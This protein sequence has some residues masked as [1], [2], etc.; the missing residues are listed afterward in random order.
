MQI[1]SLEKSIFK[2]NTF[3]MNWKQEST[4]LKPKSACMWPTSQQLLLQLACVF[5]L[6]ECYHSAGTLGL[7]DEN[8][9]GGGSNPLGGVRLKLF[10]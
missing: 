4:P 9:K 6:R 8:G 2:K 7:A 10:W 5:C 1:N 3:G